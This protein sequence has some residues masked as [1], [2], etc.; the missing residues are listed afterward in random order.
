VNHEPRRQPEA[1]GDARLARRA[2]HPRSHL[3]DSTAGLQKIGTS[4][5]VD[6]P[7]DPTPAEQARVGG[8]HD[9]IHHHLRDV[10][11]QQ[12]DPESGSD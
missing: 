10:T 9:A 1:G 12:A 7:I 5:S 2:T 6:R 11:L 3:G 8:V 4:S